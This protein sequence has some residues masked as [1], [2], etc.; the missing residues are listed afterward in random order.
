MSGA[1]SEDVT[2]LGNLIK[3]GNVL[4]VNTQLE[5]QLNGVADQTLYGGLMR[6]RW[7]MTGPDG[8]PYAPY[9]L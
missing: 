1:K 4:P 2:N 6:A 5:S 7:R 8:V 9:I 3:G